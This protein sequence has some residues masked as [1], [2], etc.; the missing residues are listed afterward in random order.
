MAAGER[1]SGSRCSLCGRTISA[2]APAGGECEQ[3]GCRAVICRTCFTV[4]GRHHC[5]VHTPTPKEPPQPAPAEAP[6]LAGLWEFLREARAAELNFIARFRTNTESRDSLPAPGSDRPLAVKQ[7][8]DVRS[9]TDSALAMKRLL[10]AGTASWRGVGRLDDVRA[11]C[12]A[13]LTCRYT[14]RKPPFVLEAACCADLAAL[15]AQGSQ[16]PPLSLEALLKILHDR[17]GEA[18]KA[19]GPILAGLFSLTG[20][21]EACVAHVVGDA[22]LP[23]LVDPDVSVCLIGPGLD[24]VRANANDRRLAPCLPLFRGATVEEEAAACKDAMYEELLATDRVFVS[25]HAREHGVSPQAALM[26]AQDLAREHEDVDLV[27]V[28][29]VGPSLKWRK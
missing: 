17:D 2:L 22:S 9:A 18:R 3:P 15:V 19:G 5:V 29:D 20:W 27:D 16:A 24:Q 4:R 25:T 23:A 21:D 10:P 11:T 1:G 26:A 6:D 28:P 13:N 12:P 14:F 7:W 8:D